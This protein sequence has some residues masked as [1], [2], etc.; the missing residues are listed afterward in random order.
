MAKDFNGVGPYAAA[1]PQWQPWF[2]RQVC[3]DLELRLRLVKREMRLA[4]QAWL[5]GD[6]KRFEFHLAQSEAIST[7]HD[8]FVASKLM[9]RG[10]ETR[11]GR[12]A[13]RKHRV[14]VVGVAQAAHSADIAVNASMRTHAAHGPARS[15][16]RARTFRRP[17]RGLVSRP[18]DD[19]G[20]GPLE[21][22]GWCR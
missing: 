7:G 21:R 19:P 17:S 15:R 3:E 22:R 10:R 2:Y 1:S 9:Y 13:I 20:P 6:I 16:P 4:K 14:A 18:D 8:A 12:E 11:W 5:R